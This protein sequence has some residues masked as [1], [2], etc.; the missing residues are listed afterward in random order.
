[1]GTE[2]VNYKKV[3]EELNLKITLIGQ[4][5][6]VLDELLLHK[7]KQTDSVAA[8]Y[9]VDVMNKYGNFFKAI[10]LSLKSSL[11][12]DLHAMLGV[13]INNNENLI[14]DKRGKSSVFALALA[15]DNEAAYQKIIAT[16]KN[17]IIMISKIRH[18]IAH[19]TSL[20][21]LTNLFVPS[22]VSVARLLNEVAEF[23]MTTHDELH[24]IPGWNKPHT[25]EIENDFADDTERLINAIASSTNKQ[26]MRERY[27]AQ[28]KAIHEETIKLMGI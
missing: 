3:S 26:E 11:Y 12:V 19:A 25:L 13:T 1:M 17:N 4:K 9:Y 5:Q 2:T 22:Y 16:H 27:L 24:D 8:K 18:A 7:S 20:E 28:R 10:E 15:T 6:A 21:E 23:I 14:Q